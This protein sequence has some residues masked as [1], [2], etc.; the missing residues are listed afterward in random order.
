MRKELLTWAIIGAGIGGLLLGGNLWSGRY[1]VT[2]MGGNNNA[3]LV[4]DNWQHTMTL[5]QFDRSQGTRCRLSGP[6]ASTL[7]P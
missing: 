3:L 7:S 5:C 4:V 2:P 6:V 1:T